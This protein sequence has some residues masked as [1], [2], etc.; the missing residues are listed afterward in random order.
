MVDI[1]ASTSMKTNC[2]FLF[3]VTPHSVPLLFLVPA[4]ML[5]MDTGPIIAESGSG[6]EIQFS[7][8]EAFG[9][10]ELSITGLNESD[11]VFISFLNVSSTGECGVS[12]RFISIGGSK[13]CDEAA[14]RDTGGIR[15]DVAGSQ[16]SVEV[17]V[18]NSNS[19]NGLR[20]AKLYYVGKKG[21]GRNSSAIGYSS[22]AWNN[23]KVSNLKLRAW[24]ELGES[25]TTHHFESVNYGT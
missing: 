23:Q 9:P 12:S 22:F 1:I 11:T 15:I 4:R 2:L 20:L 10:C 3:Q 7:Q 19:P 16:T 5:C 17:K 24:V 8:N 6:G 25:V 14:A 18:K 21:Q 13:V